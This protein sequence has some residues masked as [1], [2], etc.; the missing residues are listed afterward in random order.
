MSH[1][2]GRVR[3]WQQWVG[4]ARAGDGETAAPDRP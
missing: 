2:A 3:R 4:A 1:S